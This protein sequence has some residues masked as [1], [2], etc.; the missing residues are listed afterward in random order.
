MRHLPSR[1]AVLAVLLM[2]ALPGLAHAQG[3]GRGLGRGKRPNVPQERTPGAAPIPGTGLRQFGVWLDDASVPPKGKGWATFGVG[4]W[5]STFAHQWDAPSFD[6]G[7]ALSPRVQIGVTAPV[8][9]VRYT[10]GSSASGLGDVYVAT[11][12]GLVDPTAKGRSFG[13]AVAPLLEVLGSSSVPEGGGRVHWGLPVTFERRF[14]GFRAYGSVGYFSRGAAFASGALEVAVNE[15]LTVTGAVTHARSLHAD[16]L[17]DALQ[18]APTRWDVA[19]TGA[20]VLTPSATLYGSVGRT[21]SRLD[22]NASSLAVSAG[23]SL[24]FQ[25]PTLHP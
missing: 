4:Y 22:E 24:G 23:V 8:S 18:L 9:R 13:I 20:Y 2:L 12:I 5:R 25:R 3:K 19:G 7:L 6:G 15:K 16:P 10:D 21:V 1:S 11:K 17:S 14:E